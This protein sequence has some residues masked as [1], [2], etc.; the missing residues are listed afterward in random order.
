MIF[1]KF[2]A[3]ENNVKV[4]IRG[5]LYEFQETQLSGRTFWPV[6]V[7]FTSFGVRSLSGKAIAKAT[8]H[9]KTI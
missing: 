6:P 3:I 8:G 2:N 5:Y 7:T 1:Y 4:M 9:N